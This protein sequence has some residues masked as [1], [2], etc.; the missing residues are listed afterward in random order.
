MRRQARRGGRRGGV[1]I[2]VTAR[3]ELEQLVQQGRC[4]H[5]CS[6]GFYQWITNCLQCDAGCARCASAGVCAECD[7]AHVLWNVTCLAE[8]P[9]GAYR[10]RVVS[11]DGGTLREVRLHVRIVDP[12]EG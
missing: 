6:A 5:Q 2:A 12:D 9:D 8:C 10:D 11:P 7:A 4:V 1:E 3:R